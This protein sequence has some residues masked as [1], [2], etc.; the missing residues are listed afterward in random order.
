M[1]PDLLIRTSTDPSVRKADPSADFGVRGAFFMSLF[2]RPNFGKISGWNAVMLAPVSGNAS[3]CRLVPS[4]ISI[5]TWTSS[6][7][8]GLWIEKIFADPEVPDVEFPLR[9]AIGTWSI[10]T[11]SI[12]TWSIGTWSIGTLICLATS[13]VSL[14]LATG[15]VMLDEEAKGLPARQARP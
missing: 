11:W 12:G 1:R 4:R 2:D 13:A 15:A 14:R 6:S 7:F 10:G 9:V 5:S 3:S 8:S